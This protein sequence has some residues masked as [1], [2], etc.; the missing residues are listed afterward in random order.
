MKDHAIGQAFLST[1]CGNKT[2]I[3][4]DGQKLLRARHSLVDALLAS[5]VEAYDHNGLS[6]LHCCEAINYVAPL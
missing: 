4:N 2:A 1:C 3:V 6:I 5:N